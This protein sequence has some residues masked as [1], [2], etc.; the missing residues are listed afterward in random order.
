MRTL[1]AIVALCVLFFATLLVIIDRRHMAVRDRRRASPRTVRNALIIIVLCCIWMGACIAS[2]LARP[3]SVTPFNGDRYGWQAVTAAPAKSLARGL[4]REVGRAV[5]RPAAW[6]GWWL[7]QHLGMPHRRL[8][9]ARNWKDE[10]RNAGGP[11]V[12]V[13][14]VW[15]HHVGIITGRSAKG[16]VVKSGNDGNAVRERARSLAGAI[17]FRRVS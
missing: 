8:W 6:C 10:G 2:A 1:S 17:A 9:L 14:V 15:P 4:R 5:G 16:W 12:G 11:G 7:G 3:S 13:V